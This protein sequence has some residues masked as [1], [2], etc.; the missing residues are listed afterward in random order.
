M[1]KVIFLKQSPPAPGWAKEFVEA[2]QP[3]PEFWRESFYDELVCEDLLYR[4]DLEKSLR[5]HGVRWS[6]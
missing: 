4:K 3:I 2:E 5:Q 1:T 6:T